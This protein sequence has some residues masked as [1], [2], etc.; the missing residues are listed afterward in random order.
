MTALVGKNLEE[1]LAHIGY[2]MRRF[3]IDE[4]YLGHICGLPRNTH[5]LDMGGGADHIIRAAI[6]ELPSGAEAVPA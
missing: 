3:F 1:N 2:T 5:I 4:F 6:K